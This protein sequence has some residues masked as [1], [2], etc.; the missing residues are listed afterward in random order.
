MLDTN[1]VSYVTRGRSPAA[2]V[3]LAALNIPNQPCI[4]AISE[5]E[6]RYGLVKNPNPVA[7]R[8]AVEQFLAEIIVLPWGSD[9]AIAYGN[10]RAELRV[11]G[12]ALENMD[13]LIAAHAIAAGVILVTSDKAFRHVKGLHGTEDWATDL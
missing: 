9:E 8:R 1:T 6:I 4:S 2:R 3:R 13:M 11:A 12:K 7:V 10:L 5:G